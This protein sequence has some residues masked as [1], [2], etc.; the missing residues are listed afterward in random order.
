MHFSSGSVQFPD[1]GIVAFSRSWHMDLFCH[2]GK[3][4][5]FPLS[6]FNVIILIIIGDVCEK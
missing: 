5:I 3:K 6:L 4:S 2:K 1:P